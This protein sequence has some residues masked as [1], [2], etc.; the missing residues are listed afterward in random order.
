MHNYQENGSSVKKCWLF[1]IKFYLDVIG[2][3]SFNFLFIFIFLFSFVYLCL[4]FFRFKNFIQRF[5]FSFDFYFCIC[6]SSNI[7]D[8]KKHSVRTLSKPNLKGKSLLYNSEIYFKEKILIYI[9]SLSEMNQVNL[10]W[11]I[12]RERKL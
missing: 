7:I 3:T 6:F 5:S 12:Y 11:S 1:L 8:L 4:P 10:A 2:I 9:A